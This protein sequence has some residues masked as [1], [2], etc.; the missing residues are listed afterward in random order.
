MCL[1]KW[2]AWIVCP[3]LVYDTPERSWQ[4]VLPGDNCSGVVIGV[5]G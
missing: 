1:L 2:V 4:R 5:R 3:I